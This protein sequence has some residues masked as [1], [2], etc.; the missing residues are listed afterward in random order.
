M[1]PQTPQPGS[2]NALAQTLYQYLEATLALSQRNIDTARDICVQA[3]V[4]DRIIEELVDILTKCDY[5]RFAPVPLS[6]DERAALITRTEAVIN[7]IEDLLDK[8]P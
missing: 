5:H 2:R 4:S 7:G 3:Q 8:S 1:T 6:T